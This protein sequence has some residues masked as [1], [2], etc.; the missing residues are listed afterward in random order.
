[1]FS[2]SWPA[3]HP[4]DPASYSWLCP[5]SFQAS[6]VLIS[7]DSSDDFFLSIGSLSYLVHSNFTTAEV[8]SKQPFG[9]CFP[10]YCLPLIPTVPITVPS[11]HPASNVT[12]DSFILSFLY[13]ANLKISHIKYFWYLKIPEQFLFSVAQF[14]RGVENPFCLC[15]QI[16]GRKARTCLMS[17]SISSQNTSFLH[18]LLCF[19]FHEEYIIFFLERLWQ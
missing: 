7:L 11:S 17:T 14:G 5:N 6:A 18:C 9:G 15:T 12:I 13:C 2:S 4:R 10:G 1:M 19:Y 16:I 3:A 8:G